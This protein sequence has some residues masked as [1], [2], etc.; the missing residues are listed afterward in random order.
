MMGGDEHA[1]VMAQQDKPT[2]ARRVLKEI[3]NG[4]T[5]CFNTHDLQ[6]AAFMVQRGSMLP[7]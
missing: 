4:F 3:Y 5:E 6:K 7:G 1:A 2:D